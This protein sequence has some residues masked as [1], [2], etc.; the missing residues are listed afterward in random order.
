MVQAPEQMEA[1]RSIL[2]AA[3]LAISSI[4]AVKRKGRQ[5]R[6][7]LTTGEPDSTISPESEF[8]LPLFHHQVADHK[9]E[10]SYEDESQGTQKLFALAGPLVDIIRKGKTLVIDELDRSLHPLLVRQI[11]KTFQDPIRN[12][13]GAQLI[14]STHDATLLDSD[15]LRRD[16]IWLVEKR[17]NQ[18]SELV[19]LIEFSPRKGEALENRYLSGSYGGIPILRERLLVGSTRGEE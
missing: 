12:T 8:L 7:N 3:D 15:L 14:F 4:S 6:F 13:T 1:I 19:P 17:P 9:A 11:I 16:Q 5:F 2:G 18:S 10:F